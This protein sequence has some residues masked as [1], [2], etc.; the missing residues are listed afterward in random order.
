VSTPSLPGEIQMP[1]A[2]ASQ[3]P[4]LPSIGG[5]EFSLVFCP[6][7]FFCTNF[8]LQKY[9]M[10]ICILITIFFETLKFCAEVSSPGWVL[11]YDFLGLAA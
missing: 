5:S 6:S 10:K 7:Y 1:S 11:K 3:G 2:W 4:H 9:S 8:D